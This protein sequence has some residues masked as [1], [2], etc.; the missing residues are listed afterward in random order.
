MRSKKYIL[1][2]AFL[3]VL[4]FTM[5]GMAAETIAVVLKVKGKVQITRGTQASLITL[6]RGSR[7]QDGDKLKTE[8]SCYAAVRFIDDASLLRVR[9]NST[10]TIK[11][12][13]DKNQVIKNVVLEVGTILAKVTKQRGKFE[14]STPTSV[15]SVKGTEWITEQRYNGGTFYYVLDG[16]VEITNDGGTAPLHEDET[17]Y[18]RQR[19]VLFPF[20][21]KTWKMVQISLNLNLRMMKDKRNYWNLRRRLKNSM[22]F[23]VF[24][25]I[26]IDF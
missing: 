6:K 18:V 20:L 4:A 2:I 5:S 25:I 7:L 16:A 26:H 10:C 9:A 21:M 24:C 17:G 15:A 23:K 11:G 19:M 12:K 3:L 22:C 13:K 1:S 14:I 8:K